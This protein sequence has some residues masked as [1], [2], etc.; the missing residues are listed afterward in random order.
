M[1]S[2][3]SMARKNNI[4]ALFFVLQISCEFAFAELSKKRKLLLFFDKIEVKGAIDVFIEPGKREHEATIFADSEI[5][6]SISVSVRKRTLFIDANNTFDLA[7][8]LPFLK[9]RAER[10][11]PVEIIIHVGEISEVISLENSYVTLYGI[12]SNRLS[13]I[14]ES[15]GRFHIENPNTQQL[16][17]RQDGNGII[18]LKGNPL[19]HLDLIVNNNGSVF[20]QELP[21]NRIKVLHHGGA[22]LEIHPLQFLDS[23]IYGDGN[24]I[25]HQKPDSLVIQQRGKGTVSDSLPESDALYDLNASNPALKKK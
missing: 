11:F 18:V 10:T 15:S 9:L 17:I 19:N 20:A 12:R 6:D 16:E 13:I 1:A 21:V 2:A 5:M 24:I 3:G 23:R 7:R 8:R 4:L 25:L 14:S 22:D